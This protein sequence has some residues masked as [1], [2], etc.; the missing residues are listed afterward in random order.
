M[1]LAL[2]GIYTVSEA[3]LQTD[4]LWSIPS[5]ASILHEGNT[6]LDEFRHFFF[7]GTAYA[8][9]EDRIMALKAGF[10]MYLQKPVDPAGLVHAVARVAASVGTG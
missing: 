5:A 9:N 6:D 10:Q 3:R 8:R 2:F 1:G 4:S 7:P